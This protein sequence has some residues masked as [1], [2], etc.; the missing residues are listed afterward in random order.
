MVE[1][2]PR[3]IAIRYDD[4]IAG[5]AKAGAEELNPRH[6]VRTENDAHFRFKDVANKL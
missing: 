6:S 2:L 4:N 3:I 5:L 1:K